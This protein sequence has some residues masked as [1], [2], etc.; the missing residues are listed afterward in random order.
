MA[1][2]IIYCHD[3][4]CERAVRCV[5]Y[6]ERLSSPYAWDSHCMTFRPVGGRGA[7]CA[8]FILARE[9]PGLVSPG[10]PLG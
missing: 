1:T 2:D 9:V 10:V 7:D 6:V 5:R 4:Q 3:N 8:Y